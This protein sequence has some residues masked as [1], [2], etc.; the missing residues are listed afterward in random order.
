MTLN[1]SAKNEKF[2]LL[3]RMLV[4]SGQT[5]SLKKKNKQSHMDFKENEGRMKVFTS[6]CTFHVGASQG[7]TE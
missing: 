1:H 4:L 3:K 6:V 7:P 2:D 5:G